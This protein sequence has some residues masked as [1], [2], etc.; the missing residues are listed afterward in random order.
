VKFVWDFALDQGCARKTGHCSWFVIWLCAACRK[1]EA[2]ESMA[3]MSYHVADL[4]C[5]VDQQTMM[6]SSVVAVDPCTTTYNG[7]CKNF[8][9]TSSSTTRVCDCAPGFSLDSD[10]VTCNPRKSYATQYKLAWCLYNTTYT[11]GR[12]CLCA[13]MLYNFWKPW[14]K[15]FTYR[16]SRSSLYINVFG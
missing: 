14:H 13:V 8:C 15:K 12:I 4:L 9:F 3:D 1:S 6:L 10:N 2:A 11:Y 5:S 7:G 16:K